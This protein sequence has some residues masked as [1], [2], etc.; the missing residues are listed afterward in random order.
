MLDLVLYS[1][2]LLTDFEAGGFRWYPVNDDVM[3]GRSRGGFEVEDG[4]LVFAGSLNTNG[5]G[6]ASVRGSGRLALA[7][8]EGIRLR[9]RGDGREYSMRLRQGRVSYRAKF[10]TMKG[11]WQEIRLPFK[12]FVPTWRGRT[13]DRPPVDPA[14]VES[15]GLMIADKIDGAFRLEVDSIH[16][17]RS[18]SMDRL[19]WKARPLLLF[20]PNAADERLVRQLRDLADA[21]LRDRAMVL[22]VVLEEGESRIGDRVLS[23]SSAKQLRDAFGVTSGFAL[24]LVGKDGGVK[25]SADEPVEIGRIFDQIDAM[26]MRRAELAARE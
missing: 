21:K 22:I 11:V 8:E 10:R 15:I 24:R 16:A 17:Y 7:G 20:A 25:R 13:L 18:F 3:G 2:S 14:R 4:V 1:L 9:V 5:G 26:P 19:R 6:F 12:E 23:A